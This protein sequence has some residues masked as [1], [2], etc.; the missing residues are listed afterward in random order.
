M[1]W[2]FISWGC[3]VRTCLCL[4]P[5]LTQARSSFFYNTS[6]YLDNDQLELY[7]GRLDK[8]PGANALRLRWYG[9]GDPQLVFVERKTHREKW[10]GEVS[11]KERF[12]VR[13][14][15]DA[16]WWLLCRRLIMFPDTNM[17]LSS[18]DC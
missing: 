2:P 17:H 4:A 6:V 10:M 12:T 16:E 15:G 9:A 5:S 7:H 11:V 18:T 3:C 8:T 1:R 14:V 13:F